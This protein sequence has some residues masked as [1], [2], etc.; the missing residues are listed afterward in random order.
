MDF[1]FQIRR[2]L[3]KRK[4]DL[5]GFTNRRVLVPQILRAYK[6]EGLYS[7]GGYNNG[8]LRYIIFNFLF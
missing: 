6:Q 2:V 7:R 4:G 8:M 1:D 3:Q 5:S